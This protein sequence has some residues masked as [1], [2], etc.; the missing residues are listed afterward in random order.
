MKRFK[1]IQDLM[2]RVGLSKRILVIFCVTSGEQ[3]CQRKKIQIRPR[4][5]G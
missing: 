2:S 1:K 3:M 4:R 5:V